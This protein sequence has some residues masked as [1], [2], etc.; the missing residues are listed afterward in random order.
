MN[1]K[2]VNGTKV[3]SKVS[4]DMSQ[5]GLHRAIH[6]MVAGREENLQQEGVRSSYVILGIHQ[7]PT[8]KED[9]GEF[10][11]ANSITVINPCIGPG[12]DIVLR[13]MRDGNVPSGAATYIRN[14]DMTTVLLNQAV[15]ESAGR[16]LALRNM[17][18]AEFE[19]M[20]DKDFPEQA[21]EK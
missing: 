14:H 20:M 21:E 9:D 10:G 3:K 13:L 17:E 4:L 8:G 15:S 1:D 16:S 5:M 19:A 7:I 11:F 18:P 12:N 2:K 6:K